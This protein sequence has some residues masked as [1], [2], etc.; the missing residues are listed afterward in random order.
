MIKSSLKELADLV[1]GEVAGD[2]TTIITGINSIDQA[3]RGEITFISDK[4]YLSMVNTTQ[5]SAIIVSPDYKDSK[6]TL[7]V[8]ENP[9]LAYAKIAGFFHNRPI[10][11]RGIDKNAVI[12]KNTEIGK[13]V[14][15]YP[16]VYVGDNVKI[17]DRVSLYPGVFIGNDVH[18]GEDT[19]IHANVS[20]RE[21]CII[22]KRVI[23]HCGTVI[24]SDGFGFARDGEMYHKIPQVGIVQIDDDVE[25]G[26]NNTIDRA[27]LGRTRIKRGVKTDNLVQVGHNVTVGE[28]TVLVALVGIAGS[29]EI[30]KNA[31]I[32]GQVGVGGHLKI[33]DNV[34]VGAQS[35][36]TK[37]IAPNQMI[38]GLPAI[39]HKEWLR[40]QISFTKLPKMRKT[41]RELELRIKRI[42]QDIE[43]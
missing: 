11:V 1:N 6:K 43:S 36:V 29:T 8:V 12:G 37:N 4:K 38:S 26:A 18:I 21:G 39:P 23:I 42:E 20:V 28:N 35:G 41:L 19:I 30:G 7:L 15:L 14:S 31:V 24:G 34:T 22:G 10:R 32:A 3:N 5:A 40:S 25:I 9:Y 13:D 33:G 2:E 17:E 16:F 27:A